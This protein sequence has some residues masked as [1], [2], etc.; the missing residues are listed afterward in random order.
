VAAVWK[1]RPFR[2]DDHIDRL[3]TGYRRIRIT[4]PASKDGIRSIMIE[5]VRLSKL[6]D[7]YVEVVVTRGVPGPGERDPRLWTSRLYAYAIPYVWIVRPEEQ[8][9]GR[10]GCR[11]GAQ[12]PPHPAGIS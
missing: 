3:L 8:G 9:Q 10:Y 4:P 2:L 6:R 11:R 7:A 1:G 5:S 12:H